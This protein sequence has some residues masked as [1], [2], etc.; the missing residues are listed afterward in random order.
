M[1][2]LALNFVTF[3]CI[4]PVIDAIS[5]YVDAKTGSDSNPGTFSSPLASLSGAQQKWRALRQTAGPQPVEVVVNSPIE[6][7]ASMELSGE[8]DSGITITGS[9]WTGPEFAVS[10]GRRVTGWQRNENASLWVAKVF[11]PPNVT[12][13]DLQFSVNGS[14]VQRARLPSAPGTF[15]QYSAPLVPCVNPKSFMPS[16]PSIDATGFVFEKGDIRADLHD[17]KRSVR[18]SVYHAWSRTVH[19]VKD[20]F[21]ANSTVIFNEPLP[22]EGTHDV[23]LRNLALGHSTS[24]TVVM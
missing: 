19:S 12:G 14:A 5:L 22:T 11:L 1:Q 9:R 16:C 17:L 24:H 13:A 6:L 2:R 20:L 10:A 15:Y 21:V 3:L 18:S 8:A 7:A 23:V 4:I